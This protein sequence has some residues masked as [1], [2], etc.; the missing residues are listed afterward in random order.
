MDRARSRRRRTVRRHHGVFDVGYL[1][2]I[3]N[4]TV[5]APKDENELRHMLQDDGRGITTAGSA[6]ADAAGESG[7]GVKIDDG[8]V[9]SRHRQ[10]GSRPLKAKAS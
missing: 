4:F 3:P 9:V 8:W 2:M 5:M 6:P 1:R 10:G 7:M